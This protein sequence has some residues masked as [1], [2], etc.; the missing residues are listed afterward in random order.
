MMKAILYCFSIIFIFYSCTAKESVENNQE[1]SLPL[2]GTWQLLTG[3]TIEK[4]DTVVTEYSKNKSFIKLINATHF[5]FLLHDLSK[6][7]G[8]DSVFS[9]GGGR[10][11]LVDSSYTERLQYCSDRAWEGTDFHF[12]ITIQNDTLIQRGVENVEQAGVHRI[13]IEKYVRVKN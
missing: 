11:S 7:K 13:N 6:G 1:K 5:A 9:S 3:T 8:A 4:G 10:Y 2:A 12:T